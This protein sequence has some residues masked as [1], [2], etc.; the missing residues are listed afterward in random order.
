MVRGRVEGLEEQV[1]E[2]IPEPPQVGDGDGVLEAREGGLAGQIAVFRES[3]GEELED[4]IRTQGVV[5]VLVLV[6]GEDAVDALADHA[7]QGLLGERRVAYVVECGG[8]L[9]GEADLRVVLPDRDE[10]GV[11][12]QGCGRDLDLDGPRREEIEGQ[13]RNRV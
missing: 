3:V 4:G 6:V 13:Q 1:H 10:P 7:E 8:E 12:G 5:V 2:H 9:L 11:A